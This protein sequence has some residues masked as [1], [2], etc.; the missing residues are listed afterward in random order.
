ML[1]FW[2]LGVFARTQ[3][4]WT[5]RLG[6]LSKQENYL[7][8]DF[9]PFPLKTKDETHYYKRKEKKSSNHIWKM[10]K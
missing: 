1:Y 10:K 4:V 6:V 8:D 3:I 9:V 2:L 5:V 7:S